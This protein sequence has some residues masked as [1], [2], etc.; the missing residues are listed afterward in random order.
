VRIFCEIYTSGTIV[1][2]RTMRQSL[3]PPGTDK[4]QQPK[5]CV[6]TIPYNLTC[7]LCMAHTDIGTLYYIKY[8]NIYTLQLYNI[9]HL[10]VSIILLLARRDNLVG[11]PRMVGRQ[12]RA[13]TYRCRRF[14]C[15]F[16]ADLRNTRF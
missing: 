7:M 12:S 16:F 9:Q 2:S 5:T 10:S 15:C 13:V 8:L 4:K 6:H 3:Y 11:I 14:C 1:V